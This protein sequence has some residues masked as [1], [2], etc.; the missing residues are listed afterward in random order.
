MGPSKKSKQTAV[1]SI[2]GSAKEIRVHTVV[3]YNMNKLCCFR[4]AKMSQVPRVPT[5][6]EVVA[7]VR[8]IQARLFKPV[9]KVILFIMAPSF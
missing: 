6:G 5:M 4:Q 7:E 9:T 8:R 1:C 2:D 3:S